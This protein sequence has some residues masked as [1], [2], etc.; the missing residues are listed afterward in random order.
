ML[1]ETGVDVVIANNGQ[2]ALDR[3]TQQAFDVILMD[4]QMPVMDGFE[5][6]RRIRQT[7]ADLPII[8]LSA[9]ALDADRRK[10]HEAGA[11]AH[12]A[13]PIDC[14]E[15]YTIMCRY[16]QS[17]GKQVRAGTDDPASAS[18]LPESLK[19]FD[20]QKGLKQANH[21]AD[22]YHRM[23]LRFQEQLDGTFSDIMDII[24]PSFKSEIISGIFLE[25]L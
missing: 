17:S 25:L 1:E 14:N 23:L 18:A 5:A 20:L 8:A 6:T 2:E 24:L 4:L 9:S 21:N 13:K 22:F 12:L 16:L 11:T 15:L 19:G 10:S 7:H 3:L